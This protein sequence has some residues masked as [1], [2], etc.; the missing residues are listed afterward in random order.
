MEW[1]AISFSRGSSQSRDWTCVSYVSCF[2]GEFF[3]LCYLGCSKLGLSGWLVS[4]HLERRTEGRHWRHGMRWIKHGGEQGS[5]C[6]FQ[7]ILM[8]PSDEFRTAP[9]GGVTSTLQEPRPGGRGQT[10]EEWAQPCFRGKADPQQ[11]MPTGRALW[12]EGCSGGDRAGQMKAVKGGVWEQW[13]QRRG[14]HQSLA[15]CVHHPEK[16]SSPPVPPQEAGGQRPSW[17]H[18]LSTGLAPI[19]H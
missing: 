9:C 4:E 5:M 2:A 8:N 15:Q 12:T 1:V 13:D 11:E 18:R 3:T 6:L 14:S 19:F 10:T 7:A 17:R 16:G